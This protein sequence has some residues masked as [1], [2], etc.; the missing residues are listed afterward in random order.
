MTIQ[1]VKKIGELIQRIEA[2]FIHAYIV[3]KDDKQ[4]TVNATKLVDKLHDN[5]R[6]IISQKDLTS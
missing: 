6:D 4:F 1:Q 3:S 5:I 2:D